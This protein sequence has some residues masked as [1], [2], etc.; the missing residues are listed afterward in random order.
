MDTAHTGLTLVDQRR[1]QPVLERSA[2]EAA[3]EA[4]R[5]IAIVL[6]EPS[7][8]AATPS[9]SLASGDAGEA[10]FF[11]YLAQAFPGEGHEEVAFERLERAIAALAEDSPG[12]SLCSGFAGVAWA[13]AHL[14]R[15]L[16]LG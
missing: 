15:L 9:A 6:A 13:T 11:A 12:P 1:W 14:Q 3:L 16:G 2:R 8:G 4:A 7:R 10:L 5:A